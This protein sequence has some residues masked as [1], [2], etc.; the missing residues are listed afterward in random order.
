MEKIPKKVT[1]HLMPNKQPNIIET[2]TTKNAINIDK[3]FTDLLICVTYLNKS[4][5]HTK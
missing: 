3:I 4:I 2:E 5:A 1:V